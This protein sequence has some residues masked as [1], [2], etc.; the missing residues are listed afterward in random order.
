MTKNK[1]SYW[2]RRY[3]QIAIDRDKQ[4]LEYIA[5]MQSRY[6]ELSKSIRKDINEWIGKYAMNEGITAEETRKLLSKDEQKTWRMTLEQFR[7]KAIQGGYDQELNSEYYRS[8]ISRLERLE[9]QLYFE[10]AEMANTEENKMADYLTETL[11]ETY[12][13]SIYELTDRGSFS[14]AFDKFNSTALQLAIS[15]PWMGSNFS[16]RIWK[17]HL[18]TIPD[19]LSKSLSEA[20][21]KGW[22]VDKTVN[23]MMK[24]IDKSLRNR[25][26]TLVQT[27]S[28]HIAEVAS[29]KSMEQTGVKDWEWLATL[30]VHTCDRCAKFDGKTSKGLQEEFG[31]IPNCP[32]HPN[33]RCTRVPAIE[34][35]NSKSR[36]QRDPITGKGSVEK[37]QTFNE[38]RA[39]KEGKSRE[40]KHEN[41]SAKVY[42]VVDN[43]LKELLQKDSDK[44][45]NTLTDEEQLG[46][47]KYTG[48]WYNSMNGLL[49]NPDYDLLYSKEE[50]IAKIVSLEKALSS[51]ELKHDIIAYR[52][53]SR[54][55][56]NSILENKTFDDFKSISTTR[57]IARSFLKENS[58]E[59]IVKFN[60]PKGTNGAYIGNNSQVPGEDEFTL[61]R[62]SKYIV[63]KT[64]EGLEVT[65]IG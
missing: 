27:E 13:R 45:M 7:A 6:K 33:C 22:G 64:D 39:N 20:I 57:K 59:L 11:N 42:N 19:K 24:G 14:M 16:R 8:R 43:K 61:N 54:D 9:R 58:E 63:K 62:G 18:K 25:M 2:K 17:N 12:L 40:I 47:R 5:D 60:V 50:V 35:W 4:D 3:L 55:E 37:Y 65:I 30:E 49:R 32:D 48:P 52:G 51:F 15:K 21:I 56:Y 26:T 38:W 31:F 41:Y 23:S 34:G 46:I 10:L 36:W 28:A 44:W 29:D 1:L 53:I